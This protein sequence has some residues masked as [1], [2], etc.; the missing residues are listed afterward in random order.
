MANHP[1]VHIEIPGSDPKA[2]S[3]FYADAFG[4]K[5]Q[6]DPNFDYHMFEA[7]GG[8][9]GGFVKAGESM[10]MSYKAGE[11]LLYIGTDDIDASLAKVQ[12]L[13]G[14]VL[15]PKTEIP[16]AG[17]FALFTDPAGNKLGL[18]TRMSQ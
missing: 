10:G 3:Q 1:V 18:F 6:V 2:A 16:Q 12:S 8:P 7:E 14:K 15:A 4:W 13:G 17:W 5:I 11:V 9:G